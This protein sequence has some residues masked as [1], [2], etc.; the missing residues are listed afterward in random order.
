MSPKKNVERKRGNRLGLWFFR[1]AIR[2]LGLRGAY[3]FLYFVSLYYLV[4]DR[5]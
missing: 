2:I 5:E 3:G 1:T 4:F